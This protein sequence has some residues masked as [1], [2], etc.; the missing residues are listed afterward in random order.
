[1]KGFCPACPTSRDIIE[2]TACQLS[3]FVFAMANPNPV[4]SDL[5]KQKR[6][7]RVVVHQ[8]C[9][10]TDVALAGR[11]ISV[12]LPVEVD[13]VIRDLGKQKA[14]WLRE[15]ICQAALKEGLVEEL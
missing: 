14:A 8:S 7:Q 10:P 5:L 1:M 13:Q 3:L 2:G 9:V 6:F 12:K 11:A 4:Q 15:V